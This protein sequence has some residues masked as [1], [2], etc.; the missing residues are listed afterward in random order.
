M[1]SDAPRDFRELIVWQKGMELAQ[2]VYRVARLL[3]AE[4][5]YGLSAQLRRA[6][7]SVPS[8]IAEGYARR[9]TRELVQFVGVAQGSLA[10]LQTQIEL[11]RLLGYVS[12]ESADSSLSLIQECQRL[13]HSMQAT[14]RARIRDGSAR[15]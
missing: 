3:P 1:R 7:V 8:N 15:L 2:A 14:L 10:E 12:D 4:E 13:L 6:A 9:T 5:T 11:S